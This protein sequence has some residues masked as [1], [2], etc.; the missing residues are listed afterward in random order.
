MKI[1][2]IKKINAEADEMLAEASKYAGVDDVKAKEL[3]NEAAK[4]RSQIPA[5]Y[6]R[7]NL[8]ESVNKVKNLFNAD[9]VMLKML[10]AFSDS[11]ESKNPPGLE[12]FDDEMDAQEAIERA[13]K[14]KVIS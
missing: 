10:K 13:N 1:K 7:N 5:E 3:S 2:D 14:L 8:L 4:H 12:N 9:P 11:V 6:K